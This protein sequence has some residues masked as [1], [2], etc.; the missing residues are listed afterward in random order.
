MWDYIIV[1]GGAAGCVL[2]NRLSADDRVKV[3]LLEA[4]PM[5]KNPYIH[6]PIGFS[7]LTDGPYTWGYSS[8]PQKNCMNRTIL[9]AQGRVLGGG[10]SINAMVFTRGTPADYDRWANEEG[11]PGWS[12]KEIQPYFLRSED[13]DRLSGS[14]HG[15]GGPQG[16]S[17]LVNPQ[18][19]SNVFVRAAQEFG[20][21]Y[22]GDFNGETQEGTS[23]YQTSTRNARRCS[24]ATGYLKPVMKRKN[25]TVRTGWMTSRLI[26][27]NG[28]ATGVEVVR[29][30]KSETLKASAE[31][32]VSAGAI[33]S[34]KLLM[35][36]G[37]G[38]Q[39]HLRN[40]GI[41]VVADL[42]GVGQ[43]LQDHFDIDISYELKG[44][45]SLDKYNSWHL[46]IWAGL[47]YLL[48]GTGPVTSNAVE[49]GA[50]SFS[51][52][53]QANPDLQFHFLPAAGVEA[54][55]PP[56]PSG[57]GCT[58]NSYFLRPRSR[59]SVTLQSNDPTHIPA[60]DPNYIDDPY[61]LERSVD[62]VIQSREMMSQA[63]FEPYVKLEH[64]P[65]PGVKTK[66]DVEEY[67]RQ[68][69]RTSYHHVGT[70]K[71]GT[72]EMAVVDPELKVKGVE[73]LRVIDS[74]V[75]PSLVSS[76]TYAPT[77]MIAEKAADLIM[78]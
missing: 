49:G 23:I 5:D 32:L 15:V 20:L 33:G 70:C 25:L 53:K 55:V 47:Q 41:E 39:E 68:Y 54:G 78:G 71:M 65:G 57:N 51:D 19:L 77:L 17:D 37:L 11:C 52:K 59:G 31:V 56:I 73:G 42:P 30:G 34:P 9:L 36:S 8:V 7:K 1:G 35:L 67:A 12:F 26:I 46:M 3:L 14:W 21:K 60:I 2:A 64:F 18:N 72:D 38:P 76:N 6:M 28:R 29:E 61:D 10:S 13:N 43:N 48:F 58:L 62:G 22:N 66:K 44:P 4:G 74:S 63:S 45:Y 16:V 75:M 50:F 69:G 27:E 40:K 24:S